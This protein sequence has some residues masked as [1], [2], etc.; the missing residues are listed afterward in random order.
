MGPAPHEP[1]AAIPPDVRA[2][3]LRRLTDIER[4]HDV[5]VLWAVESGSRAWG[6]A[7]PDSDYDV[8]FIYVR[9]RGRYLAVDTS[10]L[11][12]VIEQP[13][14]DD[15]DLNGWDVRKALYLFSKSNPTFM[16]WI[17]SPIV[18]AQATAFIDRAR[19]A[20]PQVYC[21]HAG[22]HHYRSM[23]VSN[24]RGVLD[25]EQ[26]AHKKYFYV[27]RP[28]LAVQWLERF[29]TP[30]PVEFARLMTLVDDATLRREIDGLRER[31]SHAAEMGTGPRI[32]AIHA[33]LE[34]ELTRVMGLAVP[35]SG[36]PQALSVV[37]RVF[38]QTLEDAWPASDGAR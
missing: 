16:E 23:A 13:I 12:E 36:P 30:A 19:D 29:R 17:H 4:D 24:S 25:Q 22:V 26:I 3:V 28:L 34:R 27:L 21:W 7:S 2:E 35:S 14:R 11:R 15:I 18:Y 31:K 33:F 9:T 6:F 8:R 38:L 37:D 32:P 5:R 10:E 1:A 20:V